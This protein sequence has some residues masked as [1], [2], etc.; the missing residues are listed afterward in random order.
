[1]EIEGKVISGTK[2]GSYF[3]SQK[4]YS[5]QFKDK[6]GFK[7]FAGTLNIQLPSENIKE[8]NR[9]TEGEIG[10]IRG[11][12]GFGDVKFIKAILNNQINGAVV[13]PV[14]TQHTSDILE[15]I[16]SENLRENLHLKDGDLVNLKLRY[17]QTFK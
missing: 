4:F 1:M 3:V 14:K 16:A 11:K 13:F 5:D 17:P 6:L 12:E 8:I 9:I 10:I 7:P 15:F 2:K